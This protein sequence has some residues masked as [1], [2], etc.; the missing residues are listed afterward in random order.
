M[1]SEA[2]L[3][4]MRQNASELVRRA[5]AGERVTITVAGRPAAVLG[6][7]SSRTW[8]P[9]DEFAAIFNGPADP[10]WAQDRDLVDG[11][12]TDPWEPR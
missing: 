12:V 7:V 11:S 2:G 1:V 10:D 5:Q 6:P 4:E 3:R 8:R 9:W